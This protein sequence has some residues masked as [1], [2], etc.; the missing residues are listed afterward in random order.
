MTE[1]KELNPYT[2]GGE[3]KHDSGSKKPHKP[4]PKEQTSYQEGDKGQGKQGLSDGYGGSG[5]DGTGASGP[6]AAA[7][8][9][10]KTTVK[11]LDN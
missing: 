6:D 3:V 10:L 7:E 11:S 8:R 1:E 9:K 2:Q 4:D 5:G